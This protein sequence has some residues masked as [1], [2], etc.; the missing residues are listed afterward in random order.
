MLRICLASAFAASVVGLACGHS[1]DPKVNDRFGPYRGTGW[2]RSSGEEVRGLYDSYGDITLQ[3]WLSLDD[4]G[5]A[6]SGNDCWGYVSPSGKEY[7]IIGDSDGTNFVDITD[8]AAPVVVEKI[9]GPNSLWRDMK[10]YGQYAYIVS[11]GG[12]G[13]QIVNMTN[14][15]LGVVTLVN[16][17]DTGG[18]S[19]THNVAINTDS[20]FLY[21]SGGGDNGLR[22]YDLNANPTNPPYVGSWITKYVHDVQ[23]VTYPPGSQYEGREIAFCCAGYNSGWTETGLSIVDVTDKDNIFVVS[24]MQHSNNNYS[25]QGW[26]TEDYQ[27]FYLND[28]LDEQNTGS[29]TTTRIIDVSNLSNPIQVGT[30]SSGSTSIDHNLY[31]KGDTMF[32]ANYRSGLRIFDISDRLSPV[33]TAWF[34]TYPG[35]DA[36]QFNGIWSNYPYFPSGTVIGSDLE[37][38]LFVW[39]VEEPTVA[40]TVLDPLPEM[41]NPAG[42]DSFRIQA[43]LASG[44]EL[45]MNGSVL[46][47]DDGSGWNESTMNIET[48]GNPAILRATFGASECGNIVDFEAVVMAT[49]GFSTTPISD[50]IMSAND[51]LTAFEDTFETN[52]GWSVDND[53]TDGQWGRGTPAGGGSRGDPPTDSDGSGQCYV[54]DN[55]SGNSD[56]DGGTTTL[57]SPILDASATD[58]I[59]EYHRWYSNDYGASPNEDIFVVR[60]S[61]DGGSSWTTLEQ[62]G[63][64]GP[65]A[66][67]G[68]YIVQFDLGSIAGIDPSDQ[69]RV[70]F[71]AS[72]LG[73]GSVV[74]AGVDGVRITSIDCEMCVGDIDG[75]GVVDVEDVLDVIAGFGTDYTVDDILVVLGAFG[76][77]C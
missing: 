48:P 49:D 47:W 62:V 10:T 41:L 45:D 24:Q 54:T 30:C 15:D 3:S 75:N 38:G 29:L 22:I 18:T 17:V 14:I 6:D 26:L 71:E 43:T 4:L 61:D 59:L 7:A 39:S 27:Y 33:Q 73:D 67:G 40:A 77:D 68:W 2:Q 44:G 13:I 16:T 76:S 11:E 56:V 23:I 42:G 64:G 19:A 9:S 34:D 55:V 52:Q 74:E 66:S 5:G 21:R 46:R 51:I 63:P 69:F 50:S 57:I 37:R 20:G 32:Q 12:S 72:D 35:S 8:P 70:A 65:E 60:V 36:A 58:S 31:I 28:E 53:C 1:D 25:H